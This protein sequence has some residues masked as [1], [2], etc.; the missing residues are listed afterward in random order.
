MK[1]LCF[2]WVYNLL[3]NLKP[4]RTFLAIRFEEFYF[5]TFKPEYVVVCEDENNESDRIELPINDGDSTLGLHTLTRAFPNAHGLK[6][7]N[8]AT[9]AYRALLY[10]FNCISYLLRLFWSRFKGE[11]FL[12]I[13]CRK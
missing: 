5:F 3:F 13:I 6:F 11:K 12:V 2:N 9:G 8:P 7:K 10:V 1:G 4:I